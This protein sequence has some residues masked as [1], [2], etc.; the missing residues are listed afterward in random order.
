MIALNGDSESYKNKPGIDAY[1]NS[2]DI[3]R[4]IYSSLETITGNFSTVT[5]IN[6]NG[7]YIELQSIL[8][9]INDLCK[10]FRSLGFQNV[11]EPILRNNIYPLLNKIQ[12]LHK[13]LIDSPN[14]LL[15]SVTRKQY[16]DDTLTLYTEAYNLLIPSITYFKMINLNADGSNIEKKFNQLFEK[17][18]S[19][20]EQFLARGNEIEEK[21]RLLLEQSEKLTENLGISSYAKYFQDE[22]VNHNDKSQLWVIIT[23]SIAVATILFAIG[24]HIYLPDIPGDTL[25]PKYVSQVLAPKATVLAILIYMLT[26][27]VKNQKSHNHNYIVNKHRKNALET[28]QAFVLSSEGTPE[29]KHAM[30]MQMTNCIFNH[31]NSSYTV[32]EKEPDI[33]NKL[34][35]LVKPSTKGS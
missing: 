31:Q 21:Q 17:F 30:L 33:A 5:F 35:D 15:N 25:T 6:E 23:F 28:F 1:K 9:E 10:T 20:Q 11:P 14:Q 19:E 13:K 3:Y 24:G 4:L 22:A 16:Y 34:L 2:P 7:K 26:W 27:S 32:T 12:D 8:L 29:I 18:Q